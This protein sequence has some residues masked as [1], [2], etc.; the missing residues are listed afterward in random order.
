MRLSR[1]AIAF[2][3]SM[4]CLSVT[5]TASAEANAY[6]KVISSKQGE[7]KGSTTAKGHEGQIV[8]ISTSHEMTSPY[9]PGT[10]LP[11]GK[12]IHQPLVITKEMD[13]TSPQLRTAFDSAETFTTFKLDYVRATQ[14]GEV[15]YLTI[16][17]TNARVAAIRHVMPNNKDSTT[18][19]LNAYENVTFTYDSIKWA[20][21]EGSRS[22]SIAN[23]SQMV[24]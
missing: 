8:V 14:T 5:P 18:A 23:W 13:S 4:V 19:K 24:H 3:T 2:I 11:A 21:T 20:S 1:L 7:L 22:E 6:L 16:T 15:T 9:D 17:L 10:G 12:P